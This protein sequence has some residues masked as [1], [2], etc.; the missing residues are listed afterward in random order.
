MLSYSSSHQ[1]TRVYLYTVH[2]KIVGT[3]KTNG[4][5]LQMGAGGSSFWDA[6]ICTVYVLY[7]LGHAKTV[8]ASKYSMHSH[9]GNPINLHSP[10]LQ[11]LGIRYGPI[12]LQYLYCSNYSAGSGFFSILEAFLPGA[13]APPLGAVPGAGTGWR[14]FL[15][16]CWLF[17]FLWWW[18]LGYCE[19][20]LMVRFDEISFVLWCL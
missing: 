9:Q 16:G 6:P 17:T 19:I 1:P 11:C 18:D 2:L 20:C 5:F 8:T 14:R 12:H 10:L 3:K 7:L 4:F 13:L 15:D